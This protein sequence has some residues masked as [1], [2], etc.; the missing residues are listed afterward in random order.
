[1]APG[2]VLVIIID[3]EPYRYY[4]SRNFR[5]YQYFIILVTVLTVMDGSAV[6][7]P[8]VMFKDSYGTQH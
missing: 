4:F 1:M 5:E 2:S 8:I 7:D 3:P 6:P